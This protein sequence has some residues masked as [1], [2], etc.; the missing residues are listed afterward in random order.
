MVRGMGRMEGDMGER[1]KEKW[2]ERRKRDAKPEERREKKKQKQGKDE[3]EGRYIG[4]KKGE[5]RDKY[6]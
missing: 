1:G 4:N 3:E 5:R 6:W 2:E